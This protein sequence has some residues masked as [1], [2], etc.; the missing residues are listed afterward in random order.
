M[1]RAD[2]SIFD[3]FDR[4]LAESR[5]RVVPVQLLDGRDGWTTVD[6]LVGT[7]AGAESDRPSP[8]RE[9]NEM[10][11]AH[12]EIPTSA[13]RGL[14]ES[15]RE[16]RVVTTDRTVHDRPYLGVTGDVT[17]SVVVT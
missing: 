9:S 7:V 14:L 17:G 16:P 10:T 11:L 3:V 12:S 15:D 5:R 1:T 6:E 8:D 2:L 13:G 4:R